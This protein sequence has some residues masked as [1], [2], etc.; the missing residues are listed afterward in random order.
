MNR[1]KLDHV[2]LIR[3]QWQKEMPELDVEAL[4]V[5]GRVHRLSQAL[6]HIVHKPLF[7]KHDLQQ[8]EFDVLA[9]LLRSGHPYAKS[10]GELL[11]TLMITSGTMT[12]RIDRLEQLALIK[13]EVVLGD[14]RSII[15]RLTAKGQEVIRRAVAEHVET[16]S[17]FLAILSEKERMEFSRILR[18]LL[19]QL[20][21]AG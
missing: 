11:E 8:P 19:I 10:P 6:F 5:I 14:R 1:D 15:I 16:E 17:N 21:S 7:Q 9:A 3:A 4:A 20:E 18:K 12:N 2:D 13:R